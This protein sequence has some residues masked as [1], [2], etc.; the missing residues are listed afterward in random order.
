MIQGVELGCISV[1][2]HNIFLKSGLVSGVVT[3]GVRP[4]LPVE[5]V[6]MLLGNDLARNKVI[7]DPI[8]VNHPLSVSEE[9]SGIKDSKVFPAC[10]ITRAM[11]QKNESKVYWVH[12]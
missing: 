12:Y 6:S 1:P 2:L 11:S 4:T 8:V 5:G 10:A 3:V 9:E 7:E